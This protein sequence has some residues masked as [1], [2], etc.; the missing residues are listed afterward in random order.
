[1]ASQALPRHNWHPPR[2]NW[3]FQAL[4]IPAMAMIG[5]A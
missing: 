3:P 5:A 4:L 2:H 1:M